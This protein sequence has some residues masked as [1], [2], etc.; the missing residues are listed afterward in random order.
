MSESHYIHNIIVDNIK[1]RYE[2]E[3]QY[4]DTE[5]E[6]NEIKKIL[7]KYDNISKKKIDVFDNKMNEIELLTMKKLFYRLKEPHKINRLKLYFTEKY[8]M[9]EEI[10]QKSANTIIELL[11]SNTLKSKDI[12]Y[13]VE[14]IKVTNIKYITY[15]DNTHI[16]KFIKTNKKEKNDDDDNEEIIDTDNKKPKKIVKK[17]N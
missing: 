2:K 11:N 3:L 15:D 10:S 14:N 7:Q 16:I 8:N 12:E 13:D 17:K 9:N 6:I 1:Q 5:E 4:T